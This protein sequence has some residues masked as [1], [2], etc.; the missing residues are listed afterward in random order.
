MF[1]LFYPSSFSSSLPTY[2]AVV[3][4]SIFFLLSLRFDRGRGA[5]AA[6]SLAFHYQRSMECIGLSQHLRTWNSRNQTESL[7]LIPF[8]SKLLFS[9]L[10]PQFVYSCGIGSV[11]W[12][13][14]TAVVVLTKFCFRRNSFSWFL[15][16]GQELFRVRPIYADLDSSYLFGFGLISFAVLRTPCWRTYNK[17]GTAAGI[18]FGR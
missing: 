11:F 15:D 13:R 9:H 1:F 10:K 12:N 5:R 7:D 18:S 2:V 3:I 16:H 4:L 17:V 14:I 6:A 8:W